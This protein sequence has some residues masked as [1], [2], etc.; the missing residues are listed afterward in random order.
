MMAISLYTVPAVL[1]ALGVEDY[2]LYGVIG[3]VVS[4]LSFV[5]GS[6]SSGTQRFIAFEIGTG[7]K[8]A[9]KKTFNANFT[10][11]LLLSACCLAFLETVGVWF[12]NNKMVIPEGRIQVANWVYQFSVLS[13]IIGLMSVPFD[14]AIIA[15]EKMDIYAYTTLLSAFFKL[16][17]VFLL[18]LF[19][20]D[21]LFTYAAL[22]LGVSIVM[23]IIYQVYCSRHFEECRSVKIEW[24]GD[25]IKDLLGYAMYNVIG[26]LSGTLS[27]SGI[28]VVQNLF[29]GTVVNAA[30]SVSSQVT[31]VVASFTSNVRMAVKPQIIKSYAAKEIEEMWRLVNRSSKLTFYLFIFLS[32]P[33]FLE[34]P[35]ILTIWLKTPPDYV[36]PICR[37]MFASDLVLLLTAPLV[38]VFQA[39]NKLRNIQLFSASILLLAVPLSYLFLKFFENP[40]IPYLVMLV[41]KVVNSAATLWIAKHDLNMSITTYTKEVVFKDFGCLLF[42]TLV[43]FPIIIF[44]DSSFFRLILTCIVSTLSTTFIVWVYGTDDNEKWFVTNLIRTKILKRNNS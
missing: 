6:M 44:M 17:I 8:D 9:L 12:L 42:A 23:R 14:A 38:G 39:A 10:V 16:A 21:H 4:M 3:G 37:L 25:S 32:V 22:I 1:K 35:Y 31:G 20:W 7:D 27:T 28:N 40:L 15:H 26:A 43:T 33:L 34:M 41:L 18:Q 19:P 29:F 24:K 11:Y 5:S 30:H 36:Y 13:F 2:G